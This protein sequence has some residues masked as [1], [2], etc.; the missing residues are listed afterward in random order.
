MR[1]IT[2]NTTTVRTRGLRLVAASAA[3]AL[4]LAALQA[5]AAWAVYNN[6]SQLDTQPS[7]TFGA[8]DENGNELDVEMT[9]LWGDEGAEVYSGS[10]GS[11]SYSW[12]SSRP[13]EIGPYPRDF[14]TDYDVTCNSE[15][16]EHVH[17]RDFV[18]FGSQDSRCWTRA[19][20]PDES[21]PGPWGAALPVTATGVHGETLV[22]DHWASN[23]DTSRCGTGD[24][25]L[26]QPQGVATPGVGFRGWID[27]TDPSTSYWANAVYAP[28]SPD[29]SAPVISIDTALN[30]NTFE[31]GTAIPAQYQCV[32]P[33]GVDPSPSCVGD[34]PVGTDLDTRGTGWHSFTVTAEDASGNTRHLTVEYD[35]VDTTSPTVACTDEGATFPVGGAGSITASVTDNSDDP[36]T[37]SQPADTT[38]AGPHSY[39]FST[40]DNAG[41][42]ASQ[43][44]HYSVSGY[45]WS[46][47]FQPVNNLPTVNTAKAGSAIPVKFSLGGDMGL[48]V[49][50]AGSPTTAQYD[51]TAGTPSDA[52][53]TT[54]TA[55][56]SSLSYDP[57]TQTYTY[58]LKS[59]KAWRGTCRTLD[60]ETSDGTHHTA[61]FMFTK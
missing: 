44:C 59:N 30:C 7:S 15:E 45:A 28:I 58:V 38:T 13:D 20:V 27:I 2:R 56:N 18:E 14:F 52:I 46:G 5:Q 43:T 49:L 6:G 31:A 33:G 34:V 23:A 57:D 19:W 22:F 9:D 50:A 17:T 39:T 25:G 12:A 10:I 61:Q 47:F 4:G 37:L 40:T 60:L 55:G 35:I 26:F 8:F 29:T 24:V 3:C 48:D 51:C 42:P 1:G 16:E 54:V 53:E 21:S 36:R 41:N 11:R 32:D